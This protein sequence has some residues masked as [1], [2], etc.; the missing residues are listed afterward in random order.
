MS[1]LV[2][3]DTIFNSSVAGLVWRAEHA[4]SMATTTLAFGF[5]I[6][7][8][9]VIALNREY[10][11]NSTGIK[12]DLYE[13]A[14]TGGTAMPTI[15]RRLKNRGDEPPVQFYY[16]VTPVSLADR[17]TGFEA[18]APNGVRVGLRGDLQPFVHDSFK[19]YVLVIEN[20]GA[21]EQLFSFAIDFRLM[22]PGEDK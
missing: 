5:V 15:P 2:T 18:E 14:F 13:S 12:V 21:A 17:I 10:F 7:E 22:F 1:A 11:T 16:G 4:W 8:T 3:R 6:P 9:E 20:T 19:S